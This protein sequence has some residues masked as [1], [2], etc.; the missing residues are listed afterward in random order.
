[1]F[2]MEKLEKKQPNEMVKKS[3]QRYEWFENL[4]SERCKKD[5]KIKKKMEMQIPK[6][7]IIFIRFFSVISMDKKEE[8]LSLILK[9]NGK[10]V[11]IINVQK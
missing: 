2:E 5:K 1:M 8:S 9:K 10:L 7:S 4:L 6:R 11:R 3:K